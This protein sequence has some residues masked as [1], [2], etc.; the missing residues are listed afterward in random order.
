MS[1]K[2]IVGHEICDEDL[3]AVD[4]LI[5]QPGS[6]LEFSGNAIKEGGGVLRIIARTIK[7]EQGNPGSIIWQK[8]GFSPHPQHPKAPAGSPHP[9]PSNKFFRGKT[10]NKGVNGI[11]GDTG[12]R[13]HNAPILELWVAKI[14][15]A[16]PEIDI[17]G[18]DAQVGG[19]GQIGGDGGSG[20][21]GKKASSGWFDCSRGGGHGGHGCQGASGGDGGDG[22]RGGN[23]GSV[24]IFAPGEYHDVIDIMTNVKIQGGAGGGGGELSIGGDG[25]DPGKGGSG[26]NPWCKNETN[27]KN[28]W[29]AKGLDGR[30]GFK[31]TK[32]LNG[33]EGIRRIVYVPEE[34]IDHLL[35]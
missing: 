17:R 9:G 20:Q 22:G 29:G 11:D 5:F 10:G 32:G 16:G 18:Q 33:A 35:Q 4:T 15:G 14:V 30:N 28:R 13:G 12:E 8:P 2:T 25:G 19:P 1:T 23:G 21:K 3:I 31:G 34:T 6:I 7:C 24:Y 26:Q 27:N